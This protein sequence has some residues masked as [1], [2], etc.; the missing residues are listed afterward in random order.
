ML[1]YSSPANTR[2]YEYACSTTPADMHVLHEHGPQRQLP[3]YECSLLTLLCNTSIHA[4][5]SSCFYDNRPLFSDRWMLFTCLCTL[6]SMRCNK[7]SQGALDKCCK[8]LPCR[9][10]NP[11]SLCL[12]FTLPLSFRCLIWVG[13]LRH[14]GSCVFLTACMP[15]AKANPYT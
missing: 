9:S 10:R 13:G 2:Y 4:C 14:T 5:P 8:E 7:G 3:L 6:P 11:T 12:A 15:S 1:L